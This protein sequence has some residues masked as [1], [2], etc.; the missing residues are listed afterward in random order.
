VSPDGR[1][2][3]VSR[4][5]GPPLNLPVD[6]GAPVQ[7]Q[8]ALIDD[9]P[10]RWSSDGRVLFVRRGRTLPALIERIEASSGRRSLWR[11]VR[12]SERAGVFGITSLV[13]APDAGSYAY[14][15]ASSVGSLYL[16]EGI[17]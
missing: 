6:G 17:R 11:E 16:A 1:W 3:T 7:V 14:T 8:G 13:V 9:Q 2:V 10:L 15:F 12:P 5:N 4:N